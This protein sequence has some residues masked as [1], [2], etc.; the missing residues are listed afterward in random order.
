MATA[1]K[2][3]QVELK[4]GYYRRAWIGV[5]LLFPLVWLFKNVLG[6]IH[7]EDYTIWYADVA[8]TL[9]VLYYLASIRKVETYELGGIIVLEH[10]AVEVKRGYKFVP[11]VLCEMPTFTRHPQQNQFPGE[12]EEISGRSDDVEMR[13]YMLKPIRATS[14]D[15]GIQGDDVLGSRLTIEPTVTVLWQI[16]SDRFF[17]FYLMIPGHDW[18]EKKFFLLKMLRDTAEKQL[19]AEVA[20]R[21]PSEINDQQLQIAVKI[22]EALTEAT[23]PWGINIL[24]VN[25][26]GL[27]PD[28]ETNKSL[29]R[30]VV[31]RADGIATKITAEATRDKKMKEG[32]GDAYAR[33]LILAAEG[34]GVRAA[35]DAVNMEPNE[36]LD[37]TIAEKVFGDKTV[38]IGEDGLAKVM[39]IA[40]G[41][42]A[43]EKNNGRTS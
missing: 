4:P 38:V 23:G 28:H 21:T 33:E 42:F 14:K 1:P 13:K 16:R 36:Y 18:K 11:R 30:I 37:R 19:R 29:I 5:L 41:L 35:A 26:L 43:K 17:E 25:A 34:K 6:G 15:G 12:P 39:G 2:P 40:K 24:E 10:E 7:F 3:V 31:A 9:L 20:A 32:E 8:M 22:T 27:G